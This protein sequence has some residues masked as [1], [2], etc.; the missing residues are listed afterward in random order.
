MT[1]SELLTSQLKQHRSSFRPQAD[2]KLVLSCLDPLLDWL[3]TYGLEFANASDG[4]EPELDEDEPR[5][6][7]RR[8]RRKSGKRRGKRTEKV[9]RNTRRRLTNGLHRSCLGA[10]GVPATVIDEVVP[11]RPQGIGEWVK[12]V[13]DW[14]N[15]V[16]NG[17]PVPAGYE[18]EHEAALTVVTFVRQEL[19]ER[20]DDVRQYVSDLAAE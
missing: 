14:I 19:R 18:K 17:P 7:R 16:R 15:R 13:R 12:R 10:L 20:P 11:D 9:Y 4:A 3:R 1:V 8:G 6:G 5:Q 2:E